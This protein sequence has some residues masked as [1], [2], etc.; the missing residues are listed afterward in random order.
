MIRTYR[1]QTYAYRGEVPYM[2]RDGT[3]TTLSRWFT[4]CAQCGEPFEATT[5]THSLEFHPSRRC[6]KHKRPGQRVRSA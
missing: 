1:G 2:K 3:E 5:P 6:A 4:H